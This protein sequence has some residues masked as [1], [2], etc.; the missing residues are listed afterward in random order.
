MS[1]RQRVSLE[2]SDAAVRRLDELVALCGVST[3]AELVRRSLE[4]Y[5]YL[6]DARMRGG[7]LVMQL[8]DGREREL[9]V[10]LPAG[11]GPAPSTRSMP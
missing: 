11:V 9:A 1:E 3:R 5:D 4:A 8:P 10:P 6:V 7:R 2:M